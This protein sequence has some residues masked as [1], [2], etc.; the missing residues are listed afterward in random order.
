MYMY[1]CVFEV[2]VIFVFNLL[3]L[4]NV[5]LVLFIEY[6]FVVYGKCI[7]LYLEYVIC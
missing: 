7:I 5:Y 6:M 2:K 4:N 1:I 3:K